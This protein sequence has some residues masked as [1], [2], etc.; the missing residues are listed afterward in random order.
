MV[1]TAADAAPDGTSI[2]NSKYFHTTIA[3]SWFL[4]KRPKVQIKPK[5]RD[6]FYF[7]TIIRVSYYIWYFKDWNALRLLKTLLLFVTQ[8]NVLISLLGILNLSL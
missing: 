5:F 7:P 6:L 8:E 3:K 4:K 2:T 1:Q